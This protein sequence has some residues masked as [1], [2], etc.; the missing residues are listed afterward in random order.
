MNQGIIVEQEIILRKV[1]KKDESLIIKLMDEHWGGEPLV[2][3]CKKYYP[4]MMHGILA[5]DGQD[6]QGLLTYNKTDQVYEII[7]LHALYQFR[8]IGTLLLNKFIKLVKS[9]GGN[10]IVVMTT[11]DNIDALRFYQRRGFTLSALRLNVL[12]QARKIKATI[13]EVGDY[14]ILLKDEILLE[15][16][17]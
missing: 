3:N 9:E 16:S 1:E 17:V 15:L 7:V 6:C 2:V 10:K 14:G 8:G 5:F 11:N 13:P 4:S 12:S